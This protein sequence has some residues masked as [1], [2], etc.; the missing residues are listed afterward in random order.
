MV[1]E[2]CTAYCSQSL[3][4]SGGGGDSKEG[5]CDSKGVWRGMFVKVYPLYR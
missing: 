5:M 3:G 1:Y 2:Q 4:D